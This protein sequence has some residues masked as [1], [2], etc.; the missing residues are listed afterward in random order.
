MLPCSPLNTDGFAFRRSNVPE[1]DEGRPQVPQVAAG[2]GGT[3]AVS[4][5]RLLVIK[6]QVL[7]GLLLRQMCSITT[8]CVGVAAGGG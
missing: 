4:A 1:A 3:L 6:T 5:P 2:V 7:L 8:A